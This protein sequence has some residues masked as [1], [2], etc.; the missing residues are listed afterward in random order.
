[1]I[2]YLHLTNLGGIS[3]AQLDFGGPFIAITGESGAGKTSLVRAME[4]LSGK[5]AQ[6]STIRYGAEMSTLESRLFTE[7]PQA[8]SHEGVEPSEGDIFIKRQIYRNGRGKC[9]LQD[10]QVSLGLLAEY[11]DPLLRIQSQF[12]QLNLLETDKQLK[13]LDSCGGSELMDL[14]DHFSKSYEKAYTLEK[15]VRKLK[16]E[17]SEVLDRFKDAEEILGLVGKINP[18]SD[19]DLTWNTELDNLNQKLSR[20]LKIR[21]TLF[22]FRGN[23]MNKGIM[24]QLEEALPLLKELAKTEQEDLFQTGIDSILDRLNEILTIC[25]SQLS[26]Q[27][28]RSIQEEIDQKEKR[29][30]LLRKAKRIA[31][32]NSTEELIEY[33]VQARKALS[34]LSGIRQEIIDKEEESRISRKEASEAALRLR[35]LRLKSG[36]EL[37]QRVNWAM[38]DL[39]MLGMHFEVQL[40]QLDKIRENGADEVQFLLRNTEGFSGPIHKVASGGELSRLLLSIEVSLPDEQI[41]DTIVFD[42]VEAGLGGRAAVL[43]GYKLKELSRK[44]QVIL[45][46]HEASIAAIADQHFMVSKEGDQAKV[47]EVKGEA[48]VRE[49]A[50]ML[51]GDYEMRE[52]LDHARKLLSEESLLSSRID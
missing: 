15:E 24:D 50:R 44:C 4:L 7:D 1:L 30:G 14:F 5:R 3:S 12:A 2:E 21:E 23:E 33:A 52:A 40:L 29:I 17:R 41:P 20:N 31:G 43:A 34:W 28:I 19:C 32:V 42:E 49:L 27:D 38:R 16:T 36:D 48:R 35:D 51:S 8:C 22:R 6:T 37:A 45:I 13:I 47:Q 25:E 26:Q 11:M 10:H 46:T 18:F 39:A 9:F